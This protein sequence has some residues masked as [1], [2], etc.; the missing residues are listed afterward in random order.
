M[1]GLHAINSRPLTQRALR[2]LVL[3]CRLCAPVSLVFLGGCGQGHSNGARV[4]TGIDKR[5][6]GSI[7][8]AELSGDGA[9]VAVR[10][11]ATSGHRGSPA[12]SRVWLFGVDNAAIVAASPPGCESMLPDWGPDGSYL[13][14]LGGNGLFGSGWQLYYASGPRAPP[15]PLAGR[16]RQ[17]LELPWPS[18]DSRLGPDGK[19][20][21]VTVRAPKIMDK[22]RWFA[23]LAVPLD[24][25]GPARTLWSVRTDGWVYPLGVYPRPGPQGGSM[26]V[27]AGGPWPPHDDCRIIALSVPDGAVLWDVPFAEWGWFNDAA[28][29][30]PGTLLVLEETERLEAEKESSIVYA[31][32]LGTGDSRVFAQVPDECR[33]V[34]VFPAA[35]GRR[36]LLA[37]DFDVWSVLIDGVPGKPEQVVQGPASL[38]TRTAGARYSAEHG[39]EV[40]AWSWHVLWRCRLGDRQVQPVLGKPQ[41]E[42]DEP[43]RI[44]RLVPRV[45]QQ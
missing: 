36:L 26:A 21:L 24:S 44:L 8:E 42:G 31:V 1:R 40:Y 22:A 25:R 5:D 38:R 10:G 39:L 23:V 9:F 17:L 2:W 34:R 14:A 19:L 35:K 13:L 28:L 3:A 11:S 37:G 30:D 18:W 45:N 7:D 27:F 33:W 20:A 12:E 15:R 32:D 16:G 29:Y 4:S 6:V 41:A 43:P